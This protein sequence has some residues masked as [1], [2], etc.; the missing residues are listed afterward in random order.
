MGRFPG[1]V[2]SEGAAAF[3]RLLGSV[4]GRGYSS[5][6]LTT[7]SHERLLDMVDMK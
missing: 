2:G 7:S 4:L 6:A 3:G 5:L 1:L